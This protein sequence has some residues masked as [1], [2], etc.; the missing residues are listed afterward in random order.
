MHIRSANSPLAQWATRPLQANLNFH[1]TTTL[2]ACFCRHK[3]AVTRNADIPSF[4]CVIG[5]I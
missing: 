1:K 5:G 3:E 4:N 2:F